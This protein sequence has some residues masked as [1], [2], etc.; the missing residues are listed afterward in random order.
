MKRQ[1]VTGQRFGRL[2]AVK[3]LHSNKSGNSIWLCNCDC[4][5]V[6]N[7][8]ISQL[9]NGKTKSCGCINKELTKTHGMHSSPEYKSHASMK[10]RCLNRNNPQ[11]HDYGG[12]GI[13]YCMRWDSFENF[14]KDM[15]FR[16]KGKTLDRI[17]NDGNYDPENCKWST[18]KEQMLNTRRNKFYE[19]EG[20]KLTV[21]QISEK[22]KIPKS[23]LR[24]RL[25]DKKMTIQN[26]MGMV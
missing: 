1:D 6:S 11:Y 19:I 14:F 20:E 17:D 9:R 12:R 3:R 13:S 25:I 18:R 8:N 2:T 22:Y 26:A 4:G 16:P 7:S 23:T 24:Y 21:S 15:G 5:G 10:D